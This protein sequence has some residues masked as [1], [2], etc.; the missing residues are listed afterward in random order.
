MDKKELQILSN[1]LN[2]EYGFKLILILL[3]KLGAFERGIN[4]NDSERSVFLTMGKREQGLW[5]LDNVYR[6]SKDKYLK[7]LE[8]REKELNHE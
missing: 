2:D 3:E 1:V 6:T 5:L 8:Q 4:R 7:L